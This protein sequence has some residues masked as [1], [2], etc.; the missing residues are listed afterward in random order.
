MQEVDAEYLPPEPYT[1]Y[2]DESKCVY[3][4]RRSSE[5]FAPRPN[6]G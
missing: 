6:F 5:T 1:S 2:F 4:A 3:R